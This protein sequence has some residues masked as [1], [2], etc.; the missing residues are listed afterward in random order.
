[1]QDKGR[2]VDFYFLHCLLDG[3]QFT[4]MPAQLA[5]CEFQH[6]QLEEITF[7]FFTHQEK[8]ACPVMSF[9]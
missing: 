2:L 1:M 8:I 3:G 4:S 5:P 6:S 9:A 7:S